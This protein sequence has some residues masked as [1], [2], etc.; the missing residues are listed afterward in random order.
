MKARLEAL[1]VLL[2]LGLGL[3]KGLE[4]EIFWDPNPS[5]HEPTFVFVGFS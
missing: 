2:L 5:H 1:R 3:C 4:S